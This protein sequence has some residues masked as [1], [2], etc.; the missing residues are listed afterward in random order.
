M[1]SHCPTG[2]SNKRK[3]TEF[4]KPLKKTFFHIKM[5]QASVTLGNECFK[6]KRN[7]LWCPNTITEESQW[8]WFSRPV[9]CLSQK[10][11]F[12]TNSLRI[13]KMLGTACFPTADGARKKVRTTRTGS[14]L[15]SNYR[16]LQQQRI[17]ILCFPGNRALDAWHTLNAYLWKKKCALRL[18]FT[19]A[20]FSKM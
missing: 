12:P 6:M 2:F 3:A 11:L 4:S 9:K 1:E 16:I 17:G 20:V 8:C 10:Y 14:C 18:L 15:C 5:P 19:S 7:S 13:H